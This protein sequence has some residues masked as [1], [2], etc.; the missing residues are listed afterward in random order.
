MVTD[1]MWM[2][3]DYL[4]AAAMTAFVEKQ[5]AYYVDMAGK[6]GIRK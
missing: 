5:A 3:L 4:D 1:R 6:I 2:N